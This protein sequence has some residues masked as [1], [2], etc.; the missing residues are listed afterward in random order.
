MQYQNHT[1]WNFF[2]LAKSI[3]CHN[4]PNHC[5]ATEV[6]LPTNHMLHDMIVWCRT[7]QKLHYNRTDYNRDSQNNRNICENNCNMSHWQ[8]SGDMIHMD[9][10]VTVHYTAIYC[11]TVFLHTV[12]SMCLLLPISADVVTLESVHYKANKKKISSCENQVFQI[13][14]LKS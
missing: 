6:P 2:F 5:G 4:I 7:Q 12:Y 3:M 11:D 1:S 14:F 8:E 9:A 13:L 10:G